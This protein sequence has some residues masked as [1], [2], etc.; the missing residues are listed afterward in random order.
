MP[1][2]FVMA[3]SV[4]EVTL[5]VV[6][7]LGV[8]IVTTVFALRLLGG[9]RGWVTALLAG[10]VGW[11]VAALLTLGVNDWDWGAD[12]LILQMTVVSDPPRTM[13]AAVAIDL[14]SRPG[15]LA[16]AS[17]PDSSPRRDRSGPCVSVSPY[18]SGIAA[19]PSRA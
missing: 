15:S 5:R 2:S 1:S 13:A 3:A 10:A 11:T 8:A 18:Y 12:G 7:A 9:R 4:G 6:T 16:Q 17:G 14:L 19:R